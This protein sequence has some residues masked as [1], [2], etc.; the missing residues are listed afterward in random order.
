MLPDCFQTFLQ[1]TPIAVLARTCLES[2]FQPEDL[3]E[4]FRQTAHSQYQHEL[5]FSQLVEL[6]LAVVLRQQPSVHAAYRYL[7]NEGRL[8]VS[9]GAVYEKL[10][11]LELADD[12]S[13][14]K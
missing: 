2:L 7:R 6:M 9:P 5:L 10:D 1:R 8:R 12:L 3:D 14:D 13:H 4:L 11:R